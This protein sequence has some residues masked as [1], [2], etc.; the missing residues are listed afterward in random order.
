MIGQRIK[1]ARIAAGLSLRQL[2][3]KTNNYVS[4]Q[5]IHKY[6]LD[7]ATPGSD[8]LLKLAKALDVKVEF[9]FRPSSNVVT[10]GEPA[11][12]KRFET[13]AKELEAIRARAKDWVEKYLEVESLFPDHRFKPF[14]MPKSSGK[15]IRHL[16]QIEEV[17]SGV[18]KEWSLGMDPI[19]KLTEVLEDRGVK[20][21]MVATES[22]V[23]GLSCWVNEQIPLIL[24]KKNQTSDRLRF[25]I[26][27]ELGHLLLKLH[28]SVKAE[29][30]ADRFAGAFL[31]PGVAARTELG[32]KRQ[33]FNFDELK[34]LRVKYGMSVQAWIY[35]AHDLDIISDS[36]FAQLFQFLGAKGLKQK[37]IGEQL[38]P[39][40]A[41][42]FERLVLQ[43]VEEDLISPAKGAELLNVPLN[44]FRK[45]LEAGALTGNV[46]P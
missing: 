9:F 33:S 42:R 19:D 46:R 41:G 7:K 14:K 16:D 27:H 8:V 26:A 35:R 36:L 25:S 22:D 12:R 44:E 28:D 18:R 32:E 38:P 3:D 11:Y 4:A 34:S 13:S 17:A 40:H 20:V 15:I 29:K 2:A 43:A 1:Q 30:A 31:V 10:L 37:E 23:D 24:V 45:R 39:E 6:E 5:G 21:A